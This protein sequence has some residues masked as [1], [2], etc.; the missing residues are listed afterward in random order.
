MSDYIPVDGDPSFARSR[1]SG[2]LNNINKEEIAMAKE[3]KR[4]RLL[5]KADQNNLKESVS[6]LEDD[7]SEIKSI[8]SQ[9]AEK[10]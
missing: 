3:R 8:L 9:I 1:V 5:E 4:L 2:V 7:I 6:K 10:L